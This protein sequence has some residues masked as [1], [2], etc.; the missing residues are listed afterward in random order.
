MRRVTEEGPGVYGG[1]LH[2]VAGGPVAVGSAAWQEWLATP[3]PDHRAFSFPAA[4]PGR[5]D[6]R[7]YWYVK[8]RVG[9]RIQRFYL[10][11]PTAVD[12][13]CLAAVAVAIARARAAARKIPGP[14]AGEDSPTNT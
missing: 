13:A 11:P 2:A 10:G 9:S 3:G 5:S 12:E 14:L 4:G 6:E 8:V 1:Y 7:P